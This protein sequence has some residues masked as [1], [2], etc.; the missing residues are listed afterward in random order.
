MGKESSEVEWLSEWLIG[1]ATGFL[2]DKRSNR[3]NLGGE[4]DGS[5]VSRL[6]QFIQP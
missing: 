2:F 4:D 1:P 6:N 3:S 5:K